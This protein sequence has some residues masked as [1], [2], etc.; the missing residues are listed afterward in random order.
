MSESLMIQNRKRNP[1][2]TCQSYVVREIFN[3]INCKKGKLWNYN[4]LNRNKAVE[5]KTAVHSTVSAKYPLKVLW[6]KAFTCSRFYSIGA[7]LLLNL[8]LK[9]QI[10][11]EIVYQDIYIAHSIV[12]N[13]E[14]DC[15]CVN[16]L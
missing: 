12:L 2:V 13:R 6:L 3:L 9:G 14:N 11:R 16:I 1:I 7:K 5:L 15:R 10:E 8:I 4:S